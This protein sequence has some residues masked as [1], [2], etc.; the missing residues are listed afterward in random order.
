M[1][2]SNKPQAEQLEE[3][4]DSDDSTSAKLVELTTK[5]KELSRYKDA[6]AKARASLTLL[7]KRYLKEERLPSHHCGDILL[8]RYSSDPKINLGKDVVSIVVFV[9][10]ARY[11]TKTQVENLARHRPTLEKAKALLL[12]QKDFPS[13]YECFTDWKISNPKMAFFFFCGMA[14][15]RLE[16]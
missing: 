14:D 15:I 4:E 5:V 2:S 1:S 16:F 3:A 6:K 12:E 7:E 8:Y 11:L 10:L 13:W 9:H